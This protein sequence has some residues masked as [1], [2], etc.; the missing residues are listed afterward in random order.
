MGSRTR[1]TLQEGESLTSLVQ[2]L[3]ETGKG[4]DGTLRKEELPPQS[5]LYFSYIDT[6]KDGALDMAEAARGDLLSGVNAIKRSRRISGRAMGTS[7]IDT[8]TVYKNGDVIWEKDYAID[9]EQKSRFVQV[10]FDS[11]SDGGRGWRNKH[12]WT[13]DLTVEGA[14]LV[15]FTV[16]GL[17]N[18][19][20]EFA[21][22]HPDD[23]NRLS[24]AAG[25]CGRAKS[26]LL[27]LNSITNDT[28]IAV[29]LKAISTLP[30]TSQIVTL[31]TPAARVVLRM[32]DAQDG[33][34]VHGMKVGRYRDTVTLR[35]IDPDVPMDREFEVVD[36]ERMRN[37]DYYYIRVQQLD[38]E[39]AWSSPI[40][41]GGEPPT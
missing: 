31:P 7:P 23:P 16:P 3:K 19:R 35:Y 14:D 8:V 20:L 2:V 21:G 12:Y 41:V 13:G 26:I 18:R 30:T 11:S 37:G 27:E 29:D 6:N 9:T 22:R 4:K 34:L 33:R 28:T 1:A 5:Q 36:T 25:S 38:N 10:A 32:A 15:D 40:W 24:F 17:E 39:V